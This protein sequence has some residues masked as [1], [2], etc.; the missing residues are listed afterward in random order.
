M[1]VFIPGLPVMIAAALLSATR[2]RWPGT[3]TTTLRDFLT[4][5]VIVIK[6]C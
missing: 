6:P 4:L 1:I 3:V 2:C 5:A